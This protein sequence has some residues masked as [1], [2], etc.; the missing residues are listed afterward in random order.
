M[1]IPDTDEDL[2][3][4]SSEEL[5]D[6]L[7]SRDAMID[8]PIIPE[9]PLDGSKKLEKAWSPINRLNSTSVYDR[10]HFVFST[11]PVL[12][13]QELNALGRRARKIPVYIG[14]SIGSITAVMRTIV[15][16]HECINSNHLT[17]YRSQITA[18][19][20]VYDQSFVKGCVFGLSVGF[21]VTLFTSGCYTLPLIFTAI[22]GKTSYWEHA[23]AW[24]LRVHCIALIVDLNE[25]L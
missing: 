9:L 25:C 16:Y 5:D 12:Y 15:C 8:N 1:N 18:K 2:L 3:G 22:Q 4:V 19:R 20:R 7:R 13:D 6:I 21:R 17:V 14:F 11:D 23:V 10:L 24:E